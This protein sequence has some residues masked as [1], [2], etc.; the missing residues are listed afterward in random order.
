MTPSP[1]PAMSLLLI[2][3]EAAMQAGF[4]RA[5]GRRGRAVTGCTDGR[6]ALAQ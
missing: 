3:D 5:L 2:E 4:Q 6:L 1:L